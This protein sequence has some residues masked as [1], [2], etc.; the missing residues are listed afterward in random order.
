MKQLM[1]MLLLLIAAR[2]SYSQESLKIVWLEEYEWKVLTN[3][4]NDNLH[5]LEIIPGQDR[6]KRW[7]LLGQMMSIKGALN[8]SMDEAQKLMFE[9]SKANYTEVVLTSIEKDEDHEYP[10]ILFKIEMPTMKKTKKA[11][12]QLWYVRQ[13]KTALFVNFIA[14]KDKKLDDAF[15]K[16]WSKVFKSSEIVQ[17]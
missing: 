14:K 13:G 10:W 4:E 2:W 17:L 8:L 15:V 6:P 3:E 9:Q 16:K 5:L 11:E 12:S 7:T 1:V